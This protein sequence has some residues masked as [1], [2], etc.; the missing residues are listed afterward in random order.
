MTEPTRTHIPRCVDNYGH[1]WTPVR[2]LRE[3]GQRVVAVICENCGQA[4]AVFDVRPWEVR[5]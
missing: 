3:P 4:H 1:S 2:A 5:P